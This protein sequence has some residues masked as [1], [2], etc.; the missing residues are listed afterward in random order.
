MVRGNEEGPG[1]YVAQQWRSTH[2][3]KKGIFYNLERCEEVNRVHCSWRLAD[4]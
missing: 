1:G 4:Y 2:F 3:K